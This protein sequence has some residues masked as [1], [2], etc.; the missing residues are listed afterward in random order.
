MDEAH[1]YQRPWFYIVSRTVTMLA[2]Y[3]GVLIYQRRAGNFNV[4]SVIG[5]AI[6]FGILLLVWLAFFAQFVLPVQTFEERRQI[7]DLLRGHLGGSRGPAIFI[8]NGQVIERAGESELSGHGVLWLDSASGVVTHVNVS[9]KN[10]F[11]PGVHFTEHGEKIAGTVDLHNQTQGIGPREKDRPFDPQAETNA[12][13]FF[14]VQNRRTMVSALTRDGIEVVPNI[15]VTFKIDA[16]PLSGD[17]PGSHFGYDKDAVSKAVINRAV[18]P[19]PKAGSTN[20]VAWNELP[21]YI[22]A[23]LWREYM[24]KFRLQQLFSPDNVLPA[25]IPI[26][27]KGLDQK[28]TEALYNPIQIKRVGP[29]EGALIGMLHELN[30]I[31]AGWAER[32]EG[33]KPVP[34]PAPPQAPARAGSKPADVGNKTA[35]QV[36]NYMVRERMTNPNIANLDENGRW[37]PGHRPSDEYTLLKK[38]GIRILNVNIGNLRFANAVEEQLVRQWTANWLVNARNERERIETLRSFAAI[39]GQEQAIVKYAEELCE[40]LD[41]H[42]Q[43]TS[44]LKEVVKFLITRTRMILI[45]NDRMHRRATNEFQALE[46]ILQWLETNQS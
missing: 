16:D 41:K 40:G 9:L 20:E 12:E 38:R 39:N 27:R 36:I 14:E 33:A 45:R 42:P 11:G 31:L 26:Q 22:A 24:S 35:L 8:K 43:E 2:L 23:D 37:V 28:D 32:C 34:P 29:L 19:S 21:A 5:D 44:S 46:E 13:E 3:A 7:F 10:T 6:L 15:S 17:Q 1:F 18:N 4:V 25:S 30:H